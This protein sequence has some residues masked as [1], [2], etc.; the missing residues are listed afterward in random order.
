MRQERTDRGKWSQPGV[1][2]RGWVCVDVTDLEEPAETCE[3]CE[4]TT[5]RFVHHMH[6]DAYPEELGVGCICAEHMEEDYERPRQREQALR[7]RARQKKAWRYRP[8]K[9]S[10]KGNLYLKTEGY[11]LTVFA[12]GD[13]WRVCVAEAEGSNAPS[14]GNLTFATM[15][16][17]QLAAFNALLWARETW[18]HRTGRQ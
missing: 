6:H 4:S 17:A 12:Q 8:W 18:P 3:M 2:H 9:E 16:E 13:G 1:P 5:I 11:V 10:R 14:Y 7:G 15:Q